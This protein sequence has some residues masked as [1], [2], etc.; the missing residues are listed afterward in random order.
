[1]E[2]EK[3]IQSG[4]SFGRSSKK[5]GSKTER[6]PMDSGYNTAEKFYAVLF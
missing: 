3:P 2:N 6:L 5:I 4:L 1:M